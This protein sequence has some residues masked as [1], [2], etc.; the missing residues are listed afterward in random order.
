M[1]REFLAPWRPVAMAGCFPVEGSQAEIQ[2]AL[3]EQ[4][5]QTASR[6][7]RDVGASSTLVESL[8]DVQC[9]VCEAWC[10][11]MAAETFRF[12]WAAYS[13]AGLAQ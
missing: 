2:V 1:L 13:E 3:E 12:P 8:D 6:A 11:A 9:D 7:G 4:A 5:V 10:V